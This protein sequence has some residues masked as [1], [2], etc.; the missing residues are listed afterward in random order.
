MDEKVIEIL[1][2]IYD[3]CIDKKYPVTIMVGGRNSG[4]SFGM[5]QVATINIH[6][7]E[8]YKLL[9]VEDVEVNVG[10]GVKNG[11][12]NRY[13]EFGLEMCFTPIKA[14]AEIRHVNG[15]NVIFRGY[16]SEAQ[17]KQV[18][19]L[20]EIT[21][22]WYEEAENITYK[23]FSALRMQLRGGN[24][25]DRQLFLTLNPVKPDGFIA[26]YFF[27]T[28]PDKIFER[29]PDG[30]PKV[31]EKNVYI[32]LE[33]GTE[34]EV[35]CI[36]ICSTYRDNPYLTP[37]QIAG[38]E[39]LKNHNMEEYEQLANCKF[40]KPQGAYFKEFTH[41]IHTCEPFTIP[42]HWRRYRTFDYGFDKFACLWIALDDNGKAY[43]YKE[44]YES[45]LIISDTIELMKDMTL[46]EENI[47]ETFAPPDMW[48]RRQETGKSV[49][50][51]Y[52]DAGIYLTRA[53]SNRAAGWLSVKEW[54]KII[55]TADGSKDTNLVIFN[56]CENLI[57]C[58]P[59]LMRDK[60]NPN[61]ID[62]KTDH[63]ITHAPDALRYFTAGRPAPT[64]RTP[65]EIT[66]NFSTDRP[67]A[68]IGRERVV[69]L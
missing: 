52:S 54:L 5:E 65:E 55:D 2:L 69:V 49:A 34:I 62:S 42:D 33:D 46:P 13:E 66:Y 61:D 4:K 37:E 22:I 57:R 64:E 31:F 15:N 26:Q 12:E 45:D 21:A 59:K 7:N 20:N 10:E 32:K 16:H 35:P 47:Y 1:P 8:D 68:P 36:V 24:P 56:N 50:E 25:E 38:I 60:A 14:P 29:F 51:Y 11:I 17:Q 63:E 41:G 58:M 30:R 67:Q 23:Q 28:Q 53:Q 39:D 44:A 18:K 27:G 43:V 6:N 19:S 40:V 3:Y 9:V 48:N